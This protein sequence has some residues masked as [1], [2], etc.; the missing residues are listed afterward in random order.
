MGLHSVIKVGGC[1]KNSVYGT[2]LFGTILFF[3]SPETKLT[4]QKNQ[5]IHNYTFSV[6]VWYL[7]CDNDVERF[8]DGD[9]F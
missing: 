8:S 9:P 6:N 7:Q 3:F 5:F 1:R 2:D 4:S